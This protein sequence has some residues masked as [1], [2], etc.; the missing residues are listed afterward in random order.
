RASVSFFV[1]T[2]YVPAGR[3]P[4]RLLGNPQPTTAGA[5]APE[6]AHLGL[7]RRSWQR[8]LPDLA[9]KFPDPVSTCVDDETFVILSKGWHWRHSWRSFLLAW[10]PWWIRPPNG[11]DD[12]S[13]Q[14]VGSGPIPVGSC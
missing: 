12:R 11:T 3:P 1:L 10:R 5:E 13:W 8:S 7:R 14:T 6:E 2:V 4:T 9:C